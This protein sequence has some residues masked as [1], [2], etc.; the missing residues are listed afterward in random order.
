MLYHQTAKVAHC[1]RLSVLKKV[2][3]KYNWEGVNFPAT[4]DDIQTFENN[5]KV[6]VNI[7]GHSGEREI[8][9]I[10]LGTIP[11]VKNDNIN[12]L[13]IKDED[14]NGHYLY[15]RKIE[16]LIHTTKAAFY[17]DRS[18]CP[19]CRNVIGKDEIYEEH[20]LRK[21]YDCHNNCNLQL[22]EEGTTMKFKSYKNTLERPFIVYADFECSLIPTDMSDKIA[23]HEPNSAAAYFVCT[24]DESRNKYYKFEGRDCVINMIEQL[25]LLA[26]R[27]VKEQQQN[28]KMELTVKDNVNFKRATKCY[29]CEGA[30]TESNKKVRD[31][32]HRTGSYRGAAH[33]ACNINY[34]SNRYLPI[35]FHN[36]RGYDSHLIIKK[37]FEVM[38][39]TEKIDAIPNSGEKF[40]T[41]SIGNMKFIDSYQFMNFS[42]E[43]LADSLKVSK[44]DAKGLEKGAGKAHTPFDPDVKFTDMKKHFNDEEMKLICQK[45]FY[46]YEF[47]DAHEKL[48][49]RATAKGSVLFKG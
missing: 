31:H 12:L 3:D 20:L 19:Y 27:C 49:H 5:N 13:L 48:N 46:P 39:G 30:F 28:E 9:P 8:N 21:H 35:V 7:Y 18:Y 14:D 22:P 6:C 34:Y 42:L 41:F 43:K 36:L 10:R 15:V 32:C 17:K 25:R 2:E 33:N 38:K 47:I 37:A 1:D 44:G 23:K 45:G 40:M 26:S 29:I 4:F 11:Y 16:S 24:F